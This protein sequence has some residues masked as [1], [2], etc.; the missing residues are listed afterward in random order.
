MINTIGRILC[1]AALCA[2][3]AVTAS[4]N[5]ITFS[6]AG[7]I[8]SDPDNPDTV[9][10]TGATFSGSYTFDSSMSQGLNTS[11]I[12][13]YAG[14]GGVFNMNVSFSGALDHSLDGMLFSANALN[15]E[16]ENNIPGPLDEYFV[17][18]ASSTDS[19]PFMD[20]ALFDFTATAFSNTSLPL[21][22]PNLSSFGSSSFELFD[23][24][25]SGQWLDAEGDITSLTCTAGCGSEGSSPV[26]EPATG[27]LLAGGLG[28]LGWLKKRRAWLRV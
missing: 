11:S 15:I 2:L 26:P 16:V 18:G 19:S 28:A 25:A 22:P 4:A 6:F 13:G 10:G 24:T 21:T 14:A 3:S 5:T 7:S 17:S 9:F 23:T 1:V 8:T 20:L 27:T 12:E